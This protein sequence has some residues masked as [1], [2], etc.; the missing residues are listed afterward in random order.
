MISLISGGEDSSLP[1]DDE[2]RACALMFLAKEKILSNMLPS[3]LLEELVSE[4]LQP[5]WLLSEDDEVGWD[6][7]SEGLLLRILFKRDSMLSFMTSSNSFG[8]SSLCHCCFLC[9]LSC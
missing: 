8:V 5:G 1:D 6:S 2:K 7:T 9:S 3:R 4:P